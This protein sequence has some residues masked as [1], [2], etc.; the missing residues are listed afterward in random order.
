MEN[1]RNNNRRDGGNEFKKNNDFK[2]RNGNSQGGRRPSA[3][4]IARKVSTRNLP[5]IAIGSMLK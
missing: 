2:G 1:R 5:T 4:P 3:K